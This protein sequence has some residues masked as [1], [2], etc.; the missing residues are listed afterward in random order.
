M[1]L[2]DEEQLLELQQLSVKYKLCIMS[3]SDGKYIEDKDLI[4][5][6]KQI[7]V[8]DKEIKYNLT[9]NLFI[10]YTTIKFDQDNLDNL[11][12]QRKEL[13][14]EMLVTARDNRYIIVLILDLF[15]VIIFYQINGEKLIGKLN[16]EDS[17]LLYFPC[18]IDLTYDGYSTY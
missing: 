3:Y 8:L 18:C 10:R 2:I 15:I 13:V 14:D 11:L 4:D 9:L 7:D 5:L 12:S 17:Y 16:R 6:C 1:I